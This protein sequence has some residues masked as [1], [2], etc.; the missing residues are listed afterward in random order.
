MVNGEVGSDEAGKNTR[1]PVSRAFAM[2]SQ[3][4]DQGGERCGVR[5]LAGALAIPPSSTF[6]VLKTLERSTMVVREDDGTYS[7]SSEYY[8]LVRRTI[9]MHASS[10]TVVPRIQALRD[11]VDETASYGEYDPPRGQLIFTTQAEANHQ[12][13]YVS[14]V[15]RWWSLTD[16][17]SGLAILAFL[18]AEV[19]SALIERDQATSSFGEPEAV[20]REAQQVRT[21]GYYLYR[22]TRPPMTVGISA[23]TWNPDGTVA[24]CVF[25]GVPAERFSAD[26]KGTLVAAVQHAAAEISRELGGTLAADLPLHTTAWAAYRSLVTAR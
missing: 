15:N 9:M 26:R 21:D 19:R 17:S 23:P 18:P 8:R 13:R 5:E 12:L 20:E 6:R 22:R 16:G 11:A 7:L 1:E 4:V 2:L 3:M 14:E 25:V 24:G 10:R